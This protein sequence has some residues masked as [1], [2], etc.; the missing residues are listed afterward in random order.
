MS[1]AIEETTAVAGGF[2]VVGHV[3]DESGFG[4]IEAVGF[5]NL[6]DD[7]AFVEHAGVGGFKQIAQAEIVHLALE[8]DGVHRGEHEGADAERGAPFEFLAGVGQ[9]R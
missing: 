4:G 7:L 3:A 1:T 2:H 8:G 5:K 9:D 6:V